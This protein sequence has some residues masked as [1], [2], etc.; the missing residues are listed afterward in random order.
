MRVIKKRGRLI[1]MIATI[2]V[3]LGL[4][5]A[6]IGRAFAGS[7]SVATT[8][9][10]KKTLSAT[11]SVSGKTEADVKRDVFPPAAATV[12]ALSVTEGQEVKA[13]QV[14]ASLDTKQLD[15]AV[16]A[17]ETAY[18]AAASQ[19]DA[20]DNAGPSSA[21]KHA[22]GASVT[23]TK[24]AYDR[25]KSA[26][27]RASSALANATGASR[28]AAKAT[29]ETA[30]GSKEQA[31]AAYLGAKAA[32]NKLNSVDTGSSEHAARVAKT[33]AHRALL[34]ARADR[35]KATLVAPI[36]GVVIFNATAGPAAEGTAQKVTVGSTVSPVSA[37]FTVVDL[38]SL[39]FVAQL[40]E[41][42]VPR[43]KT[44]SSAVVELDATPGKEYPTKVDSIRPNALQ[45]TNGG[46]VFPATMRLENA[47][48]ALRIGMGGSVEIT[49]ADVK[50]A[51]AIPIEA[52]IDDRDGQY[53]YVVDNGQLKRHEVETGV[54]T[55]NDVQVAKGLKSGDVVALASGGQL[56]DGMKVKT[57]E[58][59]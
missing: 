17:A 19:V 47:D 5:G 9:A 3:V 56:K 58:Q 59:R 45:T 39:K 7:P 48:L 31:Y 15:A 53:V 35:R 43:V 2:V 25:A 57:G 44:G 32:R 28:S 50:N 6:M 42:D 51:V 10:V 49:V 40:D 22:A 26:V 34:R 16:D 30:K 18:A 4:A 54:M 46:N 21:E 14:L 52:L 38:A 41:S 1:A 27:A 36:D 11:V 13:G 55:A 37:P 12:R 8:T 24:R 23:S 33:S 29:L 20:A